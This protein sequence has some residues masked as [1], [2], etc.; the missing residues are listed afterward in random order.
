MNHKQR[1]VKLA[2][3]FLFFTLGFILFG[4][5]VH[6][7]SNSLLIDFDIL[8]PNG[9]RVSWSHA[10]GLIALDKKGLDGFYDVYTIYPDGTGLQCL[11]CE[12]AALLPQ[13]NNGQPA[14]HPSGTCI[15]FQAQ[16]PELRLPSSIR[17]GLEDFLSGPGVGIHNN[18]WVMTPDGMQFWQM[19]HV[20]QSN[21]VLHPHFSPDG[22]HILWTH[23]ITG[24]GDKVGRSVIMLADFEFKEGKP[25][26]SNVR[27]LRPGGLQL[28]E[29]HGFSP[30]GRRLIFSAIADGGQYYDFEIYLYDL[31]T[32]E[33]IRLTDNDEWDEHAHF[34]PDGQHIVWSSSEGIPQVKIN[35]LLIPPKLDY[36]VM[37]ANGANKRR[38]TYFNDTAAAEYIPGGIVAGDLD[39]GPDGRTVAAYL[40]RRYRYAS[41]LTVL[42]EFK[43]Y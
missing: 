8:Q 22:T 16:D 18:L 5:A 9:G 31:F 2:G 36:W 20:K 3:V 14:W 43:L 38:L 24:Q 41:D 40:I 1:L 12:K 11:T 29:T 33:L 28:Y 27:S 32:G 42:L 17:E 13:K 21:G 25:Q 34:S 23:L 30:D 26:I 4:E 19:T 6:A 39:W 7:R 10:S 15:V 35:P 37:D